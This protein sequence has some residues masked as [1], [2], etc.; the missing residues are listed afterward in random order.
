MPGLGLRFPFLFSLGNSRLLAVLGQ[1]KVA[2]DRV[3]GEQRL[4]GD[5]RDFDQGT[6]WS[7][8]ATNLA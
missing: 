1:P 7:L 8:E 2:G 4:R 5:H 3:G 6:S